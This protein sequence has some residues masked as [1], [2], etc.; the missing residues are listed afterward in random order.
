MDI[1]NNS[2][3]IS[4][5]ELEDKLSNVLI[6]QTNYTKEEAIEELQKNNYSV[7]LVLIKE[8]NIKLNTTTKISSNQERFRLMRQLLDR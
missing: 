5:E 7:K 8:Y 2:F 4:K 6:R 3:K 1:S